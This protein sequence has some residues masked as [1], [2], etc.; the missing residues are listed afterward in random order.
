[1]LYGCSQLTEI[2][3]PSQVETIQREAFRDTALTAVEL[4]ASVGTVGD[5]AF[6]S[7]ME[8][9]QTLTVWNPTCILGDAIVSANVTICGYD[10]TTAQRYAEAWGNPFLVLESA[11][12]TTAVTTTATTVAESEATETQTT[13]VV[14]SVSTETVPVSTTAPKTVT[15]TTV[16][17]TTTAKT[18]TAM[19]P[20]T[21]TTASRAVGDLDGNG[22][23]NME[24]ASEILKLYV[25]Q[26]IGNLPPERE[27]DLVIA[28]VDLDGEVTITDAMMILQYYAQFAARLTED[29]FWDWRNVQLSGNGKII[30]D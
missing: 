21:T 2:E 27:E 30:F 10:G 28:D 29:T 5:N 14:A 12:E 15:I 20:T 26:G 6:S 9:M 16:A 11:P 4:P 13:T 24:D 1:M 22:W 23:I 19:L 25:M 18:T 3:I 8:T 7:E 17:T